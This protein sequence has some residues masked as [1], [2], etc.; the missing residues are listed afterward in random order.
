MLEYL[1]IFDLFLRPLRFE[2]LY[3][4]NLTA[5]IRERPFQPHTISKIEPI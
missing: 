2:L 1:I 5:E 3:L 4:T